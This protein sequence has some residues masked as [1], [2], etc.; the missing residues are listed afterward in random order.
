MLFEVGAATSAASVSRAHFVEMEL[1]RASIT[2]THI[3][4]ESTFRYEN[5]SCHLYIMEIY[6]ASEYNKLDFCAACDK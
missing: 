6:I 4:I 3:F 1:S 2:Q 5:I